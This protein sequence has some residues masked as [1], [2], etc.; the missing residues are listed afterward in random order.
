MTLLMVVIAVTAVKAVNERGENL[1]MTVDELFQLVESNSKTLQVQKTS[2]EFA[3]KGIETA[4]ASRLPDIGV[5]AAVS[6]NGNV[7]VTNRHFGDAEGYSA[8][9]VGNSFAL[10]ARQLVYAGGAVEAGIRM[11]ELGRQQAE[12]SVR[13]TRQQQRLLALGQWL[14]LYKTVNRQEVYKRNIATTQKLIDDISA[15]H[16]Q[17]MA[18][19][20]DVTRYELQM[21]SL[22]LELRK[23]QD[24]QAILNYQLCN[25]LGLA[26]VTLVPDTTALCGLR[27]DETMQIAGSPQME[28]ALLATQMAEQKVKLAK[29]ELL[30]KVSLFAADQLNGPYIYDLP[31]KDINVNNWYAGIGISYSLSALFKSNKKVQQ[32]RLGSRQSSEAKAA[33]AEQLSNQM[34]QAWTLYQQAYAELDTQQKSVLLARQNYGVINERYLGQLALVTDMLDASNTVLNAELNEVDARINIVYA[35]YRMK[36]IAGTL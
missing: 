6:Y 35:Y 4:R 24:Q 18:L 28:Q 30:P 34:Q 20:N 16:Q 9:H 26:D 13:Q 15:K 8:P 33:T 23:L 5:N 36:Y 27:A 12:A 14:D 31:P 1:K 21:E 7:L 29:S 32:A 11:A 22:K 10:E 19:R 2:V 25:L 17:G 3:N